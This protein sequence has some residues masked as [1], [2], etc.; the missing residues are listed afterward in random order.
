MSQTAE[1]LHPAAVT[2]DPLTKLLHW[3]TAVLVLALFALSQIWPFVPSRE[4]R[5]VLELTHI[6]LGVLLALAIVLRIAWRLGWGRRL[7]HAE[8][9]LPG[10]AADALHKLLYVLIVLQ[11]LAGLSKRWVRGRGVGFFGLFDIPPPLTI[12]PGLRMA[13]NWVHH[14]DAWLI[15]ALVAGH[16]GAAL[17][18]HYVIRDGVLRRM[19]RQPVA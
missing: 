19:L 5:G 4:A 1:R 2:Y 15:M 9:G 10:L 11:V 18:H 7:P 16:A 17:F 13:V 6:S 8:P 12:P 3:V 14:W